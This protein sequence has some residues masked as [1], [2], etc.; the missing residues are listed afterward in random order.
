MMAIRA[1]HKGRTALCLVPR[2]AFPVWIDAP[3]IWTFR[4]NRVLAAQIIRELIPPV[5]KWVSNNR[6]TMS[7]LNNGT[8]I[9]IVWIQL[10]SAHERLFQQPFQDIVII[11]IGAV[12]L[13][14]VFVI[15]NWPI[16]M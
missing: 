12:L 9:I 11:I 16:V 13:H 7:L 8:L 2:C 14:V 1:C 6:I 15:I 4:F 5:A 10:C 3:V